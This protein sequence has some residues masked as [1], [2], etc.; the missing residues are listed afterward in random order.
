M[1]AAA[2]IISNLASEFAMHAIKFANNANWLAMHTAAQ[3]YLE[4][5]LPLY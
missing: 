4:L 2:N 3:K 1:H 5:L